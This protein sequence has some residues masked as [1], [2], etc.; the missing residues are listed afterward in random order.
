MLVVVHIVGAALFAAS[1]LG[2]FLRR[3]PRGRPRVGGDAPDEAFCSG[4]DQV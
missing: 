4:F 3:R 2:A 1:V